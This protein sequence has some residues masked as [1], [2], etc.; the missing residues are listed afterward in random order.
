MAN[1]KFHSLRRIRLFNNRV[2]GVEKHGA[3]DIQHPVNAS[4][5]TPLLEKTCLL[6]EGVI[7]LGP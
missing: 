3:A 5:D 2:L 7:Q 6:F 4:Y 1:H